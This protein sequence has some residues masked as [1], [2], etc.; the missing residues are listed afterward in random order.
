MKKWILICTLSSLA[1][2][3]P[4][5]EL[6]CYD[7]SG[8]HAGIWKGTTCSGLAFSGTWKGYVTDDCRFIGTDKWSSVTGVINPSNHELTASGSIS[9][10]CGSIKLNGTFT[11]SLMT[12]SGNFGY[13][14]G[15]S[16]LFSGRAQ[17]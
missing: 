14:K 11:S 4:C 10:E 17:H 5:V 13:S 15:G 7:T 6:P 9:D 8:K 12:V 16:G 3:Y 1:L 2:F